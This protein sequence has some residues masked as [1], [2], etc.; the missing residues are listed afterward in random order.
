MPSNSCTFVCLG[1]LKQ[2]GDCDQSVIISAQS[3]ERILRI[4]QMPIYYTRY[5]YHTLNT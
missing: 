5:I 3:V 1:V 4:T 2:A